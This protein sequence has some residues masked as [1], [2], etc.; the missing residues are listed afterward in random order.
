MYY[1]TFVAISMILLYIST[2][3]Y[4]FRYRRCRGMRFATSY[5]HVKENKLTDFSWT[6][7]KD[8]QRRKVTKVTPW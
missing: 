6:E 4:L 3:L 2:L 5:R 1:F 7:D 8:T